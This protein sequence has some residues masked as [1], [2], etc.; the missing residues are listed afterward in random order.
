MGDRLPFQPRRLGSLTRESIEE[1]DQQQE[2]TRASP[3]VV[4]P[5]DEKPFQVLLSDREDKEQNTQTRFCSRIAQDEGSDVT[6]QKLR[7]K[8]Q[9]EQLRDEQQE[10]DD[11]NHISNRNRGRDSSPRPK[12][13]ELDYAE[14][15]SSSSSNSSSSDDSSSPEPLPSFSSSS[16]DS[17]PARQLKRQQQPTPAPPRDASASVHRP[18]RSRSLQHPLRRSPSPGLPT[19]TEFQRS[20][21]QME[22]EIL[23]ESF[24]QQRSRSADGLSGDSGHGMRRALKGT[25]MEIANSSV[26]RR[27]ANMTAA[28]IMSNSPSGGSHRRRHMGRQSSPTVPPLEKSRQRTQTQRDWRSNS[29]ETLPMTPQFTS[30]KGSRRHFMVKSNSSPSLLNTYP[31]DHD[32]PVPLP[33]R[34]RESPRTMTKKKHALQNA[35]Y[36]M[37][38][39]LYQLASKDAAWPKPMTP[40][41]EARKKQQ[42]LERSS[43][44]K[45]SPLLRNSPQPKEMTQFSSQSKRMALSYPSRSVF[46]LSNSDNDSIDSV[47]SPTHRAKTASSMTSTAQSANQRDSTVALSSGFHSRLTLRRHHSGNVVEQILGLASTK[48]A[49][50][51]TYDSMP[52]AIA[53][54]VSASDQQI[55]FRHSLPQ[56]TQSFDSP[57]ARRK[58]RRSRELQNLQQQYYQKW[59]GCASPSSVIH[60]KGHAKTQGDPPP[61]SP[62]RTSSPPREQLPPPPP[63]SMEALEWK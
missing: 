24:R 1:D 26:E 6:Q 53:A 28:T 21:F 27:R 54:P 62:K 51:A 14:W 56:R 60:A 18:R 17:P 63:P 57:R 41:G 22:D 48:T 44:R 11:T 58:S 15:K 19:V 4:P 35:L 16:S 61:R 2:E 5:L 3:L 47:S 45:T 40:K 33:M 42:P 38:E 49:A 13:H 9:W 29:S 7:S 59:Y 52:T 8:S 31:M 30:P 43:D 20:N 55:P 39:E 12:V 23:L 36:G 34:H 32:S 25:A 10:M 37:E 50:T 46:D